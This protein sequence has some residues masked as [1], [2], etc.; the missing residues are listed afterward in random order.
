PQAAGA[1]AAIPPHGVKRHRAALAYF[2]KDA[3]DGWEFGRC[4]CSML[5]LCP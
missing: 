1:P 2:K 5:P 4:G 3:A